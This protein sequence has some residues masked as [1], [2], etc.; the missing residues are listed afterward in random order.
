MSWSTFYTDAENIRSKEEN[1]FLNTDDDSLTE[2]MVT[3]SKRDM[4]LDLLQALNT[5]DDTDL[6]DILTTHSVLLKEALSYKMLEWYFLNNDLG[7]GS[8]NRYKHE[9]YKKRYEEFKSKFGTL[10]QAVAFTTI[11]DFAR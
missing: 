8:L 5:D 9:V 11:K 3:Q 2:L 10:E 1:L 7:D 6:D 4:R